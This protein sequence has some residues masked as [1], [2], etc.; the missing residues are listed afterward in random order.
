GEFP[1][2]HDRANKHKTPIGHAA[3]VKS[4]RC[5]AIDREDV[6]G[7]YGRETRSTPIL[8]PCRCSIRSDRH[9]P[10]CGGAALSVTA[11]SR[12]RCV[13]TGRQHRPYRPFDWTMVGGTP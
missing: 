7:R 12:D 4:A 2:Y 3:P 13:R 6:D 8:V 9:P 5:A 1:F 11:S 10:N